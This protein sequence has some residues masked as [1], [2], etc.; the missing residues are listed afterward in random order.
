MCVCSAVFVFESLNFWLV[1][2]LSVTRILDMLGLLR[3]A[4]VTD[5]GQSRS[6]VAT[7]ATDS[8]NRIMP[9]INWV[10]TRTVLE[11]TITSRAL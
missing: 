5:S 11:S 7:G 6:D 10:C 2:Q 9:N 1:F 8:P 3:L 4:D